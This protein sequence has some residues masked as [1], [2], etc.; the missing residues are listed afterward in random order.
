MKIRVFSLAA[1]ENKPIFVDFIPSA[2]FRRGADENSYF[3]R[4][5]AYFR[6]LLA[7]ENSLF[8]CSDHQ[9][10]RAY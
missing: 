1:D 6:R 2:Y 10:K 4:H 7:D 9:V 8:S 3:H 5:L